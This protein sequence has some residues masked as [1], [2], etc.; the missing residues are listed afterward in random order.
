MRKSLKCCGNGD[1][2]VTVK[3]KEHPFFTR[4][5]QDVHVTVPVSVAEAGL[6]ATVQVPTLDG[7]HVNVKVP[8]GTSS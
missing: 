7:G 5:G 3:V 4:E 1:L 6:G 8:A 2:F